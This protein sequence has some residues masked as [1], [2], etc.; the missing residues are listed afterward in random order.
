[1]QVS[2]VRDSKI[3]RGFAMKFL[4]IVALAS[5]MLLALSGCQ[6]TEESAAVSGPAAT[7]PPG[8]GAAPA[9][10]G[11][12]NAAAARARAEAEARAK[13]GVK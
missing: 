3:K 1:M 6:K 8:M 5:L 2:L 10:G 7:P 13:A 4:Q 9:D 12:G 11:M